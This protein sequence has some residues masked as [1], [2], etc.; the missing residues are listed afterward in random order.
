MKKYVPDLASYMS[1]CEMNYALMLRLM[2]LLRDESSLSIEFDSSVCHIHV[3][4]QTR[5]TTTLSLKLKA[6]GSDWVEPILLS[7]RLY[8]DACLAEVLENNRNHAPKA[9]HDYP[10]QKMS[11]PDDKYQRN[12]LLNECLKF[13]FQQGCGLKSVPQQG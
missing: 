7:V 9:N 4:E 2:N 8:H 13:C 11:H 5:Y 10:N 6:H 12:R 1:Q 3:T